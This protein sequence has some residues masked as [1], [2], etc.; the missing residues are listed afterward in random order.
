VNFVPNSGSLSIDPPKLTYLLQTDPG[1]AKFFAACGFDPSRPHE[2]DAALRQ[3]P[4]LNPYYSVVHTSHGTKY[5]VRCSLP[6]PNR[7]N[8]CVRTVWIIDAGRTVPRF[9]TGYASP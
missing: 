3:H 6:T 8:P 7:R 4:V 1:K 2:L 9:V 5:I